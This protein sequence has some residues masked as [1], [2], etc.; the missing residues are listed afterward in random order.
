VTFGLGNGVVVAR[1]APLVL[2]SA[3]RTHLARVQALVGLVQLVPV[4]VANTALGALAQHASPG[5]AL[6]ATAAGLGA[7][8]AWAGRGALDPHVGRGVTVSR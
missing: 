5:A 6:A 2:G 4:M 1:L 3:P 7:C 8:A